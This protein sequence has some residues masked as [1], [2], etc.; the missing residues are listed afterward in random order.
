MLLAVCNFFRDASPD[1]SVYDEAARGRPPKRIVGG[2]TLRFG[3]SDP[4]CP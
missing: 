3:V 2:L 1:S 4:A